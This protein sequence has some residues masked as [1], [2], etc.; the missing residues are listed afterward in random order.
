M[1][2]HTHIRAHAW[3]STGSTSAGAHK[4][5]PAMEHMN[6]HIYE[7]RC[8]MWSK[9]GLNVCQVYTNCFPVI[10]QTWRHTEKRGSIEAHR[11]RNQF[12]NS[13]LLAYEGLGRLEAALCMLAHFLAVGTTPHKAWDWFGCEEVGQHAEHCPEPAKPYADKG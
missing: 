6:P 5:M 9:R 3:H 4:N 12:G 7:H 11:E 10:R 8:L 2:L 1:A 13:L